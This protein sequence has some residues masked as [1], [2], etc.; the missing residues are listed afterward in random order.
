ML[1]L[2]PQ[3]E[4]Q[5]NGNTKLI[6]MAILLFENKHEFIL[7]VEKKKPKEIW[8]AQFSD[9]YPYII[10]DEYYKKS[11]KINFRGT[12]N[13]QSLFSGRYEHLLKEWRESL[14]IKITI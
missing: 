8:C 2:K 7:Y 9:D 13:K 5:K 6:K 12:F 11:A 3:E 1:S 4:Q 10:I 14:Y